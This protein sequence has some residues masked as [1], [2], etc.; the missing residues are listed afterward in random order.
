[1]IKLK[2]WKWQL[3]FATDGL[4]LFGVKLRFSELRMKMINVRGCGI[5]MVVSVSVVL[6]A[7]AV[8]VCPVMLRTDGRRRKAALT[9][10]KYHII[11]C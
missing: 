3:Q 5:S 2:N 9:N 1:M 7:S 11:S 8:P 10:N 6:A 4:W